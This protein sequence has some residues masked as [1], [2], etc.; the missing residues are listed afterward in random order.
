MGV[1]KTSDQIQFKITLPNPSQEPPASSK[2]L[3]LDFK[4][5]D[6]LCTFKIKLESQNLELRCI[7]DKWPYLN[8]D[9]NIKLKS[10]TS[11]PH[12]SPKS[13]LKGEWCSLHFQNLLRQPKFRAMVYQRP[14][15]MILEHW[16]ILSFSEK[17]KSE[18][19]T[20]LKFKL[21]WANT[22]WLEGKY[23]K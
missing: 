3:N 5:I 17:S 18:S 8:Q 7:K 20:N 4:D 13:G 21:L 23:K 15:T 22:C 16:R 12:Q 9:Q 19:Y 2:T 11:C 14:L 6:V 10:D 1:P